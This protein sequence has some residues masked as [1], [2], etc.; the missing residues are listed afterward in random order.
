[1]QLAQVPGGVP[2]MRPGTVCNLVRRLA[3]PFCLPHSV[4]GNEVLLRDGAQ[5]KDAHGQARVTAVLRQRGCA[6]K[7]RCQT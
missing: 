3:H 4:V 2:E 1:M 5:S 6:P 7:Q